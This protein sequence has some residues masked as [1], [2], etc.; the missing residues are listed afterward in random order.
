DTFSVENSKWLPVQNGLKTNE[1]EVDDFGLL[2]PYFG[3][4]KFLKGLNGKLINTIY[5]DR[6]KLF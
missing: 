3:N 1:K 5:D 4:P 2:E 6:K